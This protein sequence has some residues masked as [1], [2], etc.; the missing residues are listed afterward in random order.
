LPVFVEKKEI[1]LF[2]Y[3]TPESIAGKI[4][5]PGN[6]MLVIL[7]NSTFLEDFHHGYR[8]ILV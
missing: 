6:T 8:N 3:A 1:S 2:K 7:C 5:F 4:Y